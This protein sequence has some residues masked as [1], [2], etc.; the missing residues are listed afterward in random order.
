MCWHLSRCHCRYAYSALIA[1]IAEEISGDLDGAF[2]SVEGFVESKGGV[3]R[4]KNM[5]AVNTL[6]IVDRVIGQLKTILSS[7]S[8]TGNWAENLK[9]ATSVYND[10]GHS[11][12]MQS[13]PDDVK[14]FEVLQYELTKRQGE[15]ILH[16]QNKWKARAGRLKDEGAFRT[17]L[18]RREWDRVDA[19]KFSGKVYEVEGLKG[20]N[21]ETTTGESFPVKTALAVPRG[22]RNVD[23]ADSGP[24]QGKRALQR[25]MLQDYA[26]DVRSMLTS[27]GV[28]LASITKFLQN[29]PGFLDTAE[30]YGVPRAGR[31][32]NFLKLYPQFFRI[33]GSGSAIKVFPATSPEREEA[34]SGSRDVPAVGMP[35]I[36]RSQ[37]IP[38]DQIVDFANQNPHRPN[39]DAFRRYEIYS[40]ASSVGQARRL[41]MTPSDL[42]QLLRTGA[43][44]LR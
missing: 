8:L 22:S 5:Q 29:R 33:A 17:P 43:I 13:A 32:V 39:T 44:Q 3:L 18:P 42:R 35:R 23:L 7:Y 16:N 21:V 4:R 27:E 1:R 11:Y 26:K 9:K 30:A 20:A 34:A 2:A 14:S 41:G 37:N 10:K 40:S 38:N 19:P 6:A 28:T 24:G 15:Q 25:Q 31:F 12:L 36:A